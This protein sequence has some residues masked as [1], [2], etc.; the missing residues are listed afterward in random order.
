VEPGKRVTFGPWQLRPAKGVTPRLLAFTTNLF[1][2]RLAD[3]S[4]DHPGIS[5]V[6]S[7]F[8]VVAP[9]PSPPAL[10]GSS[11][12]PSPGAALANSAPAPSP[13]PPPP[14]VVMPPGP[15]PRRIYAHLDDGKKRLEDIPRSDWDVYMTERELV[16]C[17]RCDTMVLTF[18]AHPTGPKCGLT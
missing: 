3:W 18:D 5:V 17:P 12:S 7:G 6:F 1:H 4:E 14:P 16:T 9:A 8:E 15:R 10:S 2:Q 11:S 13:P